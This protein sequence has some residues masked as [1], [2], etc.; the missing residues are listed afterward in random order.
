[1][2][3]EIEVSK[4]LVFEM[5]LCVIVALET[6]FILFTVPMMEDL[7]EQVEGCYEIVRNG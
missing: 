1:M 6:L 7:R 3:K 2:N 4:R 5:V